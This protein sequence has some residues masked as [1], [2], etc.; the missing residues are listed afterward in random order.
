MDVGDECRSGVVVVL[1]VVSRWEGQF[2]DARGDML[3]SSGTC[4]EAR[5]C[6]GWAGVG[7][8]KI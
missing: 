2:F 6:H 1:P 4:D 5:I 3:A 8:K 7:V